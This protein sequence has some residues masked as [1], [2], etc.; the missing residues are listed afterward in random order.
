MTDSYKRNVKNKTLELHNF[1]VQYKERL[2]KKVR[3]I[4]CH[5]SNPLKICVK[6]VKLKKV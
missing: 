3:E 6:L 4:L 5:F 2:S 1:I